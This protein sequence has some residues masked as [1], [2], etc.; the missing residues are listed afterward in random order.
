MAALQPVQLQPFT[1][2]TVFCGSHKVICLFR[3]VLCECIRTRSYLCVCTRSIHPSDPSNGLKSFIPLQPE[4]GD[5]FSPLLGACP[6][7]ATLHNAQTVWFETDHP[8]LLPALDTSLYVATRHVSLLW[9]HLPK[10]QWLPFWKV[11]IFLACCRPVACG[12]LSSNLRFMSEFGYQSFPAFETL[13]AVSDQE[14]W[15]IS[16][17][18]MQHIQHSP[19]YISGCP[20][21]HAG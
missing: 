15:S 10:Y 16:S 19:G 2:S 8:T 20:S 17:D 4:G 21:L 7:H 3:F 9:Q 14:D 18:W 6:D 5:P 1:V 11:L 13:A 12:S